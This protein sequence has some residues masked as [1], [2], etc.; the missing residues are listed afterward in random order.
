MIPDGV[1]SFLLVHVIFN[2]IDFTV[3]DEFI[4]GIN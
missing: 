3:I 2:A 4:V 1:E